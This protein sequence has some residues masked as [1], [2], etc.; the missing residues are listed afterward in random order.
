M[1][2]S[3]CR[4]PARRARS[5]Q[6]RSGS[7]VLAFDTYSGF[8]ATGL[9]MIVDSSTA[10]TISASRDTAAMHQPQ[11]Q[12]AH[13]A[14]HHEDADQQ[15]L[16][17]HRIEIG[18]ELGA[19]VELARHEAVDAVRNAGDQKARQRPIHARL[20]QRQHDDRHQQEAQDR[21]QI[22]DRQIELSL[23]PLLRPAR[24]WAGR[25]LVQHTRAAGNVRPRIRDRGRGASSRPRHHGDRSRCIQEAHRPCG[26]S[27]S[28]ACSGQAARTGFAGGPQHAAP[29]P[30]AA[31]RR[32]TVRSLRFR[33]VEFT[34]LRRSSVRP[35]V[36]A[37]L[38]AAMAR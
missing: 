18:A 4:T 28:G 37:R 33:S 20:Q 19:L 5:R 32:G 23:W 2:R 3:R 7:S 36:L 22:G 35:S 34:C 29:L 6:A 31:R 10:P 17:G 8:I 30:A 27:V 13:V 25:P 1:S 15:Q 14:Q 24:R 9:P 26:R 21:D 16:V 38:V 11:R 12:F